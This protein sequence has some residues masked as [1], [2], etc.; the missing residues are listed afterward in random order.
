MT[1]SIEGQVERFAPGFRELILARSA[2]SPHD[3]ERRNPNLVGGSIT[4]GVPDFRQTIAR[5]AL[6][7]NPYATPIRGVY[8]CSASTPP[9]AGVHGLCGY[10]AAQAALR[11][12]FGV[13][14]AGRS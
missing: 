4:G 5:P 10:Y 3:L 12:V 13:T 9:G 14:S 6:R 11:A 8:I 1:S 2:M 7:S